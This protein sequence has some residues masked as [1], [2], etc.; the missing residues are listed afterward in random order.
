MLRQ[1]LEM[2]TCG[3][4]TPVKQPTQGVTYAH[5]VDKAEAPIDW[6]QSAAVIERRIRAFNPFPGTSGV[7]NG[8][9]VKL[10]SA[11]VLGAFCAQSVRAGGLFSVSNHGLD[12]AT[13]DG[14]L[15]ITRLQK[16]GGK[17]MAVADFLH[18]FAVRPGMAFSVPEL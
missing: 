5:K 1:A 8:E 18:G 15:R 13:G 9:V 17:P 12:V 14:A 2:A 16:A 7:V 3:G 4:F 11:H 10:Q 6:R